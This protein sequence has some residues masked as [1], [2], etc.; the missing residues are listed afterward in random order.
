MVVFRA[1]VDVMAVSRAT[2]LG[3]RAPRYVPQSAG[4]RRQVSVDGTDT[5]A[6]LL[7]GL[8]VSPRSNTGAQNFQ[9]ASC[10]GNNRDMRAARRVL[11]PDP[12]A[13]YRLCRC[14]AVNP[15]PGRSS[16]GQS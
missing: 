13:S 6:Q 5:E 1:G 16:S 10:R 4:A 14:D 7:R 12:S 2:R 11:T 15:E 3:P 9:L 8:E